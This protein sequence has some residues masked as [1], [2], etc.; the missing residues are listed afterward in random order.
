MAE[1]EGVMGGVSE[2]MSTPR[3]A[4]TAGATFRSG[5]NQRGQ[6]VSTSVSTS[7][8]LPAAFAASFHSCGA[9]A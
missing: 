5:T 4:R 2:W 7:S 9:G 3:L 8:G 1:G 6:T